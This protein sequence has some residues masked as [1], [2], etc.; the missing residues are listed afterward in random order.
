MTATSTANI[1]T[2]GALVG[3]HWLYGSTINGGSVHLMPSPKGL[4]GAVWLLVRRQGDVLKLK[5]L[6]RAAGPR[7][8][9]FDGKNIRLV[10]DENAP[11]NEWHVTVQH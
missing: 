4:T 10:S 5:C 1:E 8:L 7:W 6:G 3:P 2:L 9:N 11:G